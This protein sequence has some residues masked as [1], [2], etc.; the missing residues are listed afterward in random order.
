MSVRIKS[1]PSVPTTEILDDRQLGFD[2]I[3]K[4]LYIRQ[5][6]EILPVID[7]PTNQDLT[8]AI[9]DLPGI[10]TQKIIDL[11]SQLDGITKVF[12]LNKVITNENLYLNGV[13]LWKSSDYVINGTTLTIL[14]DVAP[15]N[16]DLLYI[17]YIAGTPQGTTNVDLFEIVTTL[18]TEDINTNVIYLLA[19]EGSSGDAFD[20]LAYVDGEWEQIGSVS[21]NLSD[22]YTS[23]QVDALIKKSVQHTMRLESQIN[24]TNK[25]FTL[26][27][28]V[29]SENVYL[30]GVRLVEDP[31]G[32]YTLNGTTLTI[33]R[34]EAPQTGDTLFVTHL[35]Q[36]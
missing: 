28:P 25:I 31:N 6:E 13:R 27:E 1:G 22:Y 23:A 30:N 19:K 15:K 16:T 20:E 8:N 11:A 21:I 26:T 36:E 18:P 2:T 24:N 14:R 35:K 7:A 12:E 5:G 17:V 10:A 3:G 34:A 4:R 33:T 29:E 32:D 9:S